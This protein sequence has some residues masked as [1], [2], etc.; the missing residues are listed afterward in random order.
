MSEWRLEPANSHEQLLGLTYRASHR[1]RYGHAS[2]PGPGAYTVDGLTIL[3]RD[4]YFPGGRIMYHSSFVNA[5]GQQP[6]GGQLHNPTSWDFGWAGYGP[7]S[8]LLYV[9]RN[10]Y[11]ELDPK[12][13]AVTIKSAWEIM[14]RPTR[15]TTTQGFFPVHADDNGLIYF[16]P[17]Y[18]DNTIRRTNL[19]GNDEVVIQTFDGGFVRAL[20]ITQDRSVTNY[21]LL[22]PGV[23]LIA[24][25]Y[26]PAEHKSRIFT[27]VDRGRR[28]MRFY[29]RFS[30]A[31]DYVM[32]AGTGAFGDGNRI[33]F[34]QGTSVLLWDNRDR[35]IHT[36]HYWWTEGQNHH[37][38][39]IPPYRFSQFGGGLAVSPDATARKKMRKTRS[40][41]ASLTSRRPKARHD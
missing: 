4:D 27:A 17:L 25:V 24:S 9:E 10:T 5:S 11:G 40:A 12:T 3:Y 39:P 38:G 32:V 34:T 29:E 15:V 14:L 22:T 8:K 30:V 18:E 21:E 26:F 36:I 7:L 16:V 35:A 13:H 2:V 20:A 19:L 37:S 33:L 6:W 1:S 28:G 31:Q 41:K 23:E